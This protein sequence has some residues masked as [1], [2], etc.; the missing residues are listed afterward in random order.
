MG[1]RFGGVFFLK[2]K[3]GNPSSEQG[4]RRQPILRR[5]LD[6]SVLKSSTFRYIGKGA[7]SSGAAVTELGIIG[8]EE[9]DY[10]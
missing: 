3:N 9:S 2:S 5:A 1:G 8:C 4:Y 6:F 10:L 7:R